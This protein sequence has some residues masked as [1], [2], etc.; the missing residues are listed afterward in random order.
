LALAGVDPE[1]N[2]LLLKQVNTHRPVFTVGEFPFEW[3][4]SDRSGIDVA[5]SDQPINLIGEFVNAIRR[6]ETKVRTIRPTGG[7]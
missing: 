6:P 7:S 1:L 4:E 3:N 2:E 5:G